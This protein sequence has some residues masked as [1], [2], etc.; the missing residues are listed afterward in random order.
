MGLTGFDHALTDN[1]ATEVGEYLANATNV[2]FRKQKSAKANIAKKQ[3]QTIRTTRSP[4]PR[5]PLARFS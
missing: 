3:S 2:F 4:P 1:V 5:E